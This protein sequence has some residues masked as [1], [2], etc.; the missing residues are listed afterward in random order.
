MTDRSTTAKKSILGYDVSEL[1]ITEIILRDFDN[2]WEYYKFNL[3]ERR[4]IISRIY[5][6]IGLPLTAASLFFYMVD[7]DVLTLAT[8][9][10][11]NYHAAFFALSLAML[12]YGQLQVIALALE[13]GVSRDYLRFLNNV[14]QYAGVH[15]AELQPFLKFNNYERDL[16]QFLKQRKI[17]KVQDYEQFLANR[18]AESAAELS[19]LSALDRV[20]KAIRGLKNSYWRASSA[21]FIVSLCFTQTILSIMLWSDSSL[22]AATLIVSGFASTF[23]SFSLNSILFNR[24]TFG[25]Q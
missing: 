11:A 22:E 25:R 14:R 20:E 17:G 21:I 4:D 19:V 9:S 8:K 12:V 2:S 7:N 13:S 6:F 16:T 5:T 3:E 23:I 24:L 1:A 10:D 15:S 18:Q